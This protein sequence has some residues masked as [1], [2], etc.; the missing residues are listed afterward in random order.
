MTAKGFFLVREIHPILPGVEFTG[1]EGRFSI[2]NC[3]MQGL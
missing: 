3:S 2:D 1:E